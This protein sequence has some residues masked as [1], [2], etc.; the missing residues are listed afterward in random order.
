MFRSIA[1]SLTIIALVG[2]SPSDTV[3]TPIPNSVADL[4]DPTRVF[5]AHMHAAFIDMD[6]ATYRAQVLAEMEANNISKSVLHLNEVSDLEDW[7]A[8]EPDRFLAGP[9][10]PCWQNQDGSASCDWNGE[11]W[12][13]IAWMRE[14]YLA[15]KMHIMG[16]M[17]FVYTGI[18]P[19]DPRMA[20]YWALADELEVPVAV[21]INRGP[22]P[23]SPVRPPGCCPNFDPALG[24]PALLRPILEQ[25]PDLKIWIQ[26]AGF[27]ALPMLDDIDYL[28]ETFALLSD[29]P[30]IYVD[31]TALNAA[32]PAPVHAAALQEFIDRG[33]VDRIMMGTD[34]WPADRVIARY[35]GFDFLTDAQRRA[36]LYDN[37]ARFFDLE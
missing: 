5:N 31:M 12:P 9:S 7:V 37:A 8:A 24:N 30:N 11:D 18:S 19:N 16:E 1:W 4:E 17:Y 13:D 36:I 6:D 32:V 23:D 21:H 35:D 27:P 10:F 15:G 14:N 25:Y 29:Y 2:C 33:F 22:P 28:D 20:P 3:E 34:N 26:H